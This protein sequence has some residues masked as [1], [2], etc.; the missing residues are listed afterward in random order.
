[1]IIIHIPIC[2]T[3]KKEIACNIYKIYIYFALQ[4]Q[5]ADGYTPYHIPHRVANKLWCVFQDA[6]DFLLNEKTS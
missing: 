5:E 2:S 3:K 4:K 6:A 1:M